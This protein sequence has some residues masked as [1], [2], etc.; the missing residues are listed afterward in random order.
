MEILQP[1]GWAAPIGYSDG[2]A[3]RPGRIV[4]IAGQVARGIRT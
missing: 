4:F 2:V 1:D 3:E